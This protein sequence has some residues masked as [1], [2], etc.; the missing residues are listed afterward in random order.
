M[1]SQPLLAAA[2]ARLPTH[3][4]VWQHQQTLSAPQR[5]RR[6]FR[7]TPRPNRPIHTAR[8]S[9]ESATCFNHHRIRAPH[10]AM[11]RCPTV[12]CSAGPKKA[13]G[14]AHRIVAAPS[15]ARPAHQPAAPPRRA[16]N[17]PA[18]LDAPVAAAPHPAHSAH[19]AE[20]HPLVGL[21][22]ETASKIADCLAF[23][24]AR[25]DL[26]PEVAIVLGS[27]LGAVADDLQDAVAIPFAEVPHFHAPGV[28]GHPGRLVLG[29][30]QG[31]PTL[32]LQG[33]F[34]YY[35]GHPMDEVILP[36]RM[37]KYL[38][39]HSALITNAAGGL[40]PG[41][42]AGDLMLIEDH[43]NMIGNNPL[44][45]PN[46]KE[47]GGPRFL[48]LSEPYDPAYRSILSECAA[49]LGLPQLKSGVYIGVSGPTY[50]TRAE[51]RL[52]RNM[53]ADAVG[54]STVPEVI[55]ARHLGVRVAAISC[56][57]NMACGLVAGEVSHDDVMEQGAAA[58]A[59]MRRL[60][61]AAVP[62]I[63]AAAD[64]RTAAK[65]R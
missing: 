11:M 62:R 43:I 50:E 9:A 29:T 16:A 12:R 65:R 4:I 1:P 44:R 54:M 7:S 60:L 10:P 34:H 55:A 58:A 59:K 36:I 27:G 5:R 56:V 19:P 46:P 31:V 14:Q 21:P 61:V 18:V 8:S 26:V 35:E 32:V 25:T 51:V 33:R 37:A 42:T 63:S 49:E 3:K 2:S 48:D 22:A 45:G 64:A 6:R 38:G 39:C 53:G 15:R 13:P 28:V 30:L 23:V 20:Q 17:S 47:L 40:N 41:F 52:F 24:R 57:T